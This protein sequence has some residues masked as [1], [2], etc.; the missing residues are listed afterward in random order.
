MMRTTKRF[1]A[2]FLA[3]ALLIFALPAL[4][5]AGDITIYRSNQSGYSETM[6]SLAYLD[7][8]LYL[9]PY[10][11]DHYYTWTRESGVMTEYPFDPDPTMR[12]DGGY[13]DL[14]CIMAGEDGLYALLISNDPTGDET[15]MTSIGDVTL[16]RIMF[17]DDGTASLDEGV[18]L[19]WGDMISYSDEYEYSRE[20]RNPFINADTFT[21]TTYGESGVSN[22]IFAYDIETGDYTQYEAETDA[23]ALDIQNYCS[24]GDGVGL[25]DT[26]DYSS[27]TRVVSFYT[28]DL[29]SGEVAPAFDMPVD[30]YNLPMNLLYDEKN[31]MLYYTLNGELVRI[32]GGDPATAES[33]AAVQI[34]SWSDLS[35]ALTDDGYFICSDYQSVIA[36]S[37][38]PSARA[39][40]TLTVYT[41]YEQALEGAYY[42]FA[43]KHADTDVVLAQS[44]SDMTE[45]MMNQSAAV[46]IYT[47]QVNDSAYGALFDRGYL[48][49]LTDSDKL[50]SLVSQMYPGIQSAVMKDGALVALPV[51]MYAGNSMSYNPAALEKLG[52]TEDD[53]P[54]TWVEYFQLLQK[55]PDLMGDTGVTAFEGYMTQTDA[56]NN[57]FYSLLSAYML[58]IKN[59]DGAEMAFDTPI[60]AD[61]LAEL[62]KIDFTELGLPEE[63]DDDSS[64]SYDEDTR[65]RILFQTYADISISN[66]QD[67]Y[68]TPLLLSFQEDEPPMIE[69]YLTVAF[70][71]PYSQHR[72]LAI[73]YL[74][75]TVDN[76]DKN[77]LTSV[78]PDRNDPIK[79]ASY[80]ET[81][82]YYED[83]IASIQEELDKADE[84]SKADWQ[85]Q[86][87]QYNEYF[88]EFQENG[89]WDA[90]AE[91]IARYRAYAQY[92]V[93]SKYFGL[94]D[95]NMGEFYDQ[96]QQYLNG[97]IDASTMCKN[98]DKKL[99]MMLMEGM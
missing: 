31:D 83:Q 9:F 29:A 96:I 87:D 35:P 65:A 91:S 81:V 89:A 25:I 11:G 32:K 66:Y 68:A 20:V 53:M 98:I 18:S 97:T 59:T 34:D 56:R 86:L 48:A 30:N 90:S 7:G 44:Y 57:L 52:L 63:Y 49:E 76:M 62:E 47:V 1:F 37:T 5:G 6:R 3:L 28:V 40:Q 64:Y 50:M 93:V 84:A 99:K 79:N 71:N 51:Q 78:C 19:D 13:S 23:G 38:D 12:S 4:A 46:D 8:T 24:Y 58:Y 42:T 39:A 85:T 45:A 73:E 82:T 22:E 55:L 43:A 80:D 41:G 21:F 67:A 2:A 75:D 74:E 15:G 69:T 14:R 61:A 26:Y 10:S 27:D 33:V 60:F 95:S 36:R 77:F 94:D 16:S 92:M 17:A 72:D 54:K 70:V 88:A